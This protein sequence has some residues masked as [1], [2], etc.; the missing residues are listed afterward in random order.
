M[1]KLP[2]ANFNK[3]THGMLTKTEIDRSDLGF[4]AF[5]PYFEVKE[6]DKNRFF[7]KYTDIKDKK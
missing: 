1:D 3:S 5:R 4:K 6:N 2:Q 7:N